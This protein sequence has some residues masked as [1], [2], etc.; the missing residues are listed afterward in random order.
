MLFRK[1]ER[2]AV[3][4]TELSPDLE[5]LW[6]FV[7]IRYLVHATLGYIVYLDHELD[8][9]WKSTDDWDKLQKQERVKLNAILNRATEIESAEWDRS[10]E[11]RTIKF[12]RQIGEGIARGLDGDF[13]QADKMLDK[14]EE[15][16][17]NVQRAAQR[18][19]AI[20]DQ[21]K[22]KDEWR[23]YY[24]RWTTTHYIIGVGALLS[25][26]LV[27]S[28]PTWVG[29][30]ESGISFLAWL[31]AVFTGL[32]TFL[33]PGK[34]A[35]RYRRAWSVINAQII[36]YNADQTCTTNDV[37]DG[38]LKGENILSETEEPAA[39]R[40]SGSARPQTTMKKGTQDGGG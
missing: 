18:K 38:Y 39:R 30:N 14:A 1:A 24:R 11:E 3:A 15:Y 17:I 29:F 4:R 33:T 23:D 2:K 13:A 12:R 6:G 10:D 9:D 35:D 37:L 20:A 16:R 27:A 7:S 5:Q 26:T 32:L 8:V 36:R 21:V 19:K 34:R 25:S 28:H 22:I 31:V 40:M